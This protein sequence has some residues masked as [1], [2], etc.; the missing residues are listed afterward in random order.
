M[1]LIAKDM[2]TI[3]STYNQNYISKVNI[4]TETFSP[5][6]LLQNLSFV[7]LCNLIE[8][9]V[10]YVILYLITI[11]RYTKQQFNIHNMTVSMENI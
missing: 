2:I 6:C 3:L 9:V 7:L 1:L 11:L 5:K 4:S 10:Q 8:C